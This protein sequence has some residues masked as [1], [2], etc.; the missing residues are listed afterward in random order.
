[1]PAAHFPKRKNKRTSLFLGLFG[2]SGQ[3]FFYFIKMGQLTI[4][5]KEKAGV[6]L[7]ALLLFAIWQFGY[8]DYLYQNQSESGLDWNLNRSLA[9]QTSY[10][11]KMAGYDTRVFADQTA[12]HILSLN[13][14][15]VITIDTP[16]N[17]IPMMFLYAAFILVYPGSW[18]RKLYFIAGGLFVL[19]VLNLARIIGL[20][21][22]SYY[23]PGYFAI[24][25]K[26]IFQIVVYSVTISIW[27][28][29]VLYGFDEKYRLK[30]AIRDF[31][32]FR[33]WQRIS[34]II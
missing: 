17:G 7:G 2:F 11:F 19:H 28:F 18:K 1:V 8:K 14:I 29:F 27:F 33:V 20:A 10:W 13:N 3:P 21:Y 23:A 6:L 15:K 12:P 4:L 22:L 26:F 34:Q 9:H 16:C 24:N 25:H 5:L 32:S 30:S 31:F